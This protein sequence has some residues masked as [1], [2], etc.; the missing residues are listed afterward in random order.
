MRI[1]IS[2]AGIAGPTLAYWLAHYG[3]TP[4][5]VEK[6]PCLRSGGYIVDFWGAGF[7]IAE[8]M[9]LIPEINRKGYLVREV[10]VVN[11]AGKR[12]AALPADAFSRTTRGRFISLPRGELSASIFRSITGKVETIFGDAVAGIE[13][14]EQCVRVA[15][16]QGARREFDAIVGADGLHSRIRELVFGPQKR[17]E[18]YL[19]YKVAAFEVEGYNPRDEL[20]YVMYTQVGQQVARFAMRGNRTTFLFIFAD[21]EADVPPAGDI[22]AQKAALRERFGNSGWECPQILD[23]LDN[24]DDL[25][26]D[27][28]SQVRMNPEEGLWTN[29]R[30]TLIGDA[31]SCVS[32]LAGEG[33]G[34]AMVAAYILAGE[35]HR[36]KGDYAGAFARY[37]ERFAPFVIKKQKSALRFA[38]AFAPKSKLALVLRNRILDLLQVR[39][40]ADLLVGR[41]LIDDIVI[42]EYKSH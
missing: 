18:R 41:D 35:L 14:I 23:A 8:R 40:I 22:R 26:F 31:A 38:G 16:E 3:L 30:I 20:V 39:W 27:R 21:K 15:F 24:C 25:Y 13:Q 17:F 9:G 4:T 12:V 10:V 32:L 5:L 2:G 19:G 29:G 34:L 33:S 28:V 37:Q 6:A 36:A 7:E 11:R 42:P 1:L